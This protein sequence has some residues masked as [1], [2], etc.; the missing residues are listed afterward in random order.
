MSEKILSKKDLLM[1]GIVHPGLKEQRIPMSLNVYE[2]NEL[3]GYILGLEYRT[4]I[5]S[6]MYGGC[7]DEYQVWLTEEEMTLAQFKGTRHSP[8]WNII[9]QAGINRLGW[10]K[11]GI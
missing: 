3:N 11:D 5:L 2:W 6:G 10:T 4:K 7:A 9:Q 1:Q 8:L